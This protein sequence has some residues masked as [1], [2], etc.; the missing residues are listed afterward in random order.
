[1][2]NLIGLPT[3]SLSNSVLVIAQ[4]ALATVVIAFAFNLWRSG[5]SSLIKLKPNMDSLI[6]IGTAAAY[7]YSAIISALFLLN[8][9]PL[10]PHLH[11]S[12]AVFILIFITLGKYLEELT[13]GKTGAAVKELMHLQPQEANLLQQ[14]NQLLSLTPDQI[15]Q[16][17]NPSQY[18]ETPTPITSI[19][20]NHLAV[21]RPGQ[22]I[23]IDGIVVSGQST[24]DESMLTGESKPATRQPGDEV[25]GGTI[26]Q[27]GQLVIRVTKVGHDTMLSKI[28]AIVEEAINSK[29]PIQLLADR[30]SLYFVPTVIAIALLSFLAWL[31]LGQPF[32]LALT[33][34]VSVLIIACPCALGLATPTAVMMGTGLAAQRGILVKTSRALEQAGLITTVI[35]DKTGTITQGNFAVT[36]IIPATTQNLTAD[37]LLQLAASAEQGSEHPVGQAIVKQA[38]TKQLPLTPANNFS[39]IKGQGISATIDQQQILISSPNYIARQD[40]NIQP[41]KQLSNQ[42]LP[43]QK[44]GKTVVYIVFNQQVVGII[45]IADQPK[46]QAK[47][48]ISQLKRQ[49][50]DVR[51]ITGDNLPTARAIGQLVG[52]KQDKIIAEVLPQDKAN[53]V[54]KLQDSDHKS[55]AFVGDGINDAPALAQSDLGIALSSGTDIAIETGDIVLINNNLDDVIQAINLSRYTMR[56]IKQNLFWAFIYNGLSI[57]FATGLFYSLTG[58]LINPSLAAAAMAFSSVSVVT[59][60]LLMKKYKS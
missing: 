45:A 5:L 59:N 12:S 50:L 48:T 7:I 19:A 13:K 54:K 28:I 2:G 57:P 21:V 32:S 35:F 20:V 3:P 47:E 53:Q 42:V 15:K 52:I 23:P 6:F 26:N 33:A 8:P 43:L 34:F 38:K 9:S 4:F 1:M 30:V 29:A 11:F 25:I 24:V 17:F 18:S 39:A 49:G 60:S 31:L 56:K 37:Q 36:D 58:W 46:P 16:P 22:Q 51:M 27:T 55:V 40:S 44:Q 10:L 14:N 41:D